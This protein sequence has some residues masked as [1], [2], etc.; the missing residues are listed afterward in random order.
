MDRTLLVQR[1]ATVES[2][3]GTEEI[4]ATSLAIVALICLI[5]V[6]SRDDENL[7]A[8]RI[9]LDLGSLRLEEGL[10]AGWKAVECREA[11]NLDTGG[12]S[13]NAI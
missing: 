6:R 9:P 1:H 10:L 4:Q 12:L 3:R 13:L 7:G 5:D 11:V 8:K 2:A